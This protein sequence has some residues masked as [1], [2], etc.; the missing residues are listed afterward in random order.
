MNLDDVF[1]DLEAEF[2]G[3]LAASRPKVVVER[4][5]L[6]RVWHL[7]EQIT[8]LAAPILGAD[9]VAG[10]ALGTNV[11]R[12]IR[13]ESVLKITLLELVNSDVPHVRKI[14][15]RATEFFDRLPLPFSVRMQTAGTGSFALFVV[16]DLLGEMLLVE[17]AE[18]G[19][20]QLLPL[21]SIAVIDL[22][23]VDN[24]DNKV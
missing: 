21:V 10:M 1:E 20:I 5:H 2:E 19:V 3:Y 14:P 8:E 23:D 16:I 24:F 11:F 15:L 4:S 9:F 12:L 17:S 18:D 13:L 22:I 7:R 6:L